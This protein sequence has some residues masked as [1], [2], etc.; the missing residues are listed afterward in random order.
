MA[1]SAR[2]CS[3]VNRT[4]AEELNAS[5]NVIS[6]I[7]QDP[8]ATIWLIAQM[9][10]FIVIICAAVLGNVLLLVVTRN[11]ASLS[12]AL[13]HSIMSQAL[14]GLVSVATI[15][16]FM[17]RAIQ[18]LDFAVNSYLCYG[19]YAAVLLSISLHTGHTC[20]IAIIHFFTVGCP[21]ATP[22]QYHAPLWH[23]H[24]GLTVLWFMAFVFSFLPAFCISTLRP[25][26]LCHFEN[27]WFY[28]YFVFYLCVLLAIVLCVIGMCTY[29]YSF[30][31]KSIKCAR[32]SDH[33]KIQTLISRQKMLDI[34]HMLSVSFT[35]YYV[36]CIL[37]HSVIL[38]HF[39]K[40][41]TPISTLLEELA[42]LFVIAFAAANPVTYSCQMIGFKREI[43][44]KVAWL[45]CNK[46]PR[47]PPTQEAIQLHGMNIKN[48]MTG[49]MLSLHTSLGGKKVAIPR[50][51]VTD[52]NKRNRGVGSSWADADGVWH[53]PGVTEMIHMGDF[54][55]TSRHNI[56]QTHNDYLS[57]PET[58]L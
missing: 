49:S 24:V 16:L 11:I 58:D 37:F 33:K 45:W 55:F 46:K 8:A 48:Q 19:W 25:C 52:F 7:R 3:I 40:A 20:S 31:K 26:Q 41:R 17:Y 38:H 36:P 39:L 42:F 21:A 53:S 35:V 47:L 44:G 34:S 18:P 22:G 43:Y 5:E 54:S 6:A 29:I 10:I 32:I 4:V 12:P 13:Q 15:P 23:V 50:V 14:S 51:I 57:V 56:D 30:I 1:D 2:S 27:V 28:W 9:I